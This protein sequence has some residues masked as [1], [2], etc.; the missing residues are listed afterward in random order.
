MAISM[1]DPQII[2][3]EM[4]GKHRG[5]S[6]LDIPD[7]TGRIQG[8]SRTR[9]PTAGN[10]KDKECHRCDCVTHRMITGANPFKS[11]VQGP[12][13]FCGRFTKSKSLIVPDAVIYKAAH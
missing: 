3:S 9:E 8:N 7:Q 12:S 11:N 5:A 13:L 1:V 2:G 10:R 6:I 4:C